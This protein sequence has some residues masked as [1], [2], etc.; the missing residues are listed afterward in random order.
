M[1]WIFSAFYL[2]SNEGS[3]ARIDFTDEN[4]GYAASHVWDGRGAISKTTN[5]GQGWSTVL[6]SHD[7]NGI[8]FPISDASQVGY[9]V[10][11]TGTILKTSDAGAS[12]Q[13]QDSGTTGVLRDVHFVDL[14]NG[15]VVG[16]GGIILKTTTGGEKQTSIDGEP[17]SG[18]H[19]AGRTRIYPNPFGLSLIHH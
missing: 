19:I 18:N 17:S 1:N 4:I 15:Y 2:N 16:D 10:G 12:W 6:F 7:L 9:V 8:S 14:D 11:A 5:G 13:P 3:I